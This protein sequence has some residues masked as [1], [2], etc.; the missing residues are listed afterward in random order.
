[1][2]KNYNGIDLIKFIMAIFV[3]MIHLTPLTVLG[4]KAQFACVILT[5]VAVPFFF[6]ASGFLL[7]YKLNSAKSDEQY[8]KLVLDYVK[9][10][11]WLYIIWTT[12]YLPCILFWFRKEGETILSFLQ[13]CIFDGSYVHLWYLPS[14][15]V[16]GLITAY[17][18]KKL[19]ALK[20]SVI[21]IGLYLIGLVDTSY[22]GVAERLS[23][24]GAVEIYDNIFLTTRNGL[25][26]GFA[27]VTLGFVT[28]DFGIKLSRSIILFTVSAIGLSAEMCW[29][30]E[31]GIARSYEGVIF[32]VPTTYFL[33]Q[34]AK[35]ANLKDRDIYNRLRT[36][37]ILIYLSHCWIDFTWSIL[38]FNILH[39][40]FNNM[41]R[42]MYTI[43]LA[44]ILA[45]VIDK[46][47]NYRKMSWLKKLY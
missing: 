35:K 22:Y 29:L 25:F 46:L 24:T 45:F 26:F 38:C 44:T 21:A 30:Y 1:M 4:D 6:C 20:T 36:A 43:I 37:G 13:K 19:G 12:V 40:S 23:F 9:R 32:S 16:A 28:Y 3:V 14:V 39:R 15:A 8:K 47:K 17:L 2:K 27:F 34:I 33:F 31:N 5:R 41:A 10:I 7:K 11:L 18:Y 42:F